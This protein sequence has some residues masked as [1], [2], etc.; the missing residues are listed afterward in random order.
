M[1]T[2][3][4]CADEQ[5]EQVEGLGGNRHGAI[6]VQQ[7]TAPG[8]EGEA[9]ELRN[10]AVGGL[11]IL[12]GLLT[13]SAGRSYH[14]WPRVT[15]QPQPPTGEKIADEIEREMEE[16]LY[17]L[18]NVTLAPAEYHVYLHPDDFAYVEGIV[19]RIVED[20]QTCLNALVQRL[21]HRSLWSRLTDSAAVPAN[22]S[23][24]GRLGDPSQ[25]V[26]E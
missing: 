20:V 18:R 16:R 14:S 1:T 17:P 23:A 10:H 15:R 26:G 2:F 21:N 8:V 4:A 22:R 3:G 6:S 7:Q 5:L 13:T 9:A 19:P 25:G 24:G 12:D 11:R